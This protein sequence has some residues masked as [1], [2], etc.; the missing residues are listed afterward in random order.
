[1]RFRLRRTRPP[2]QPPVLTP[3]FH[4]L[5]DLP[6]AH[7]RIFMV[8]GHGQRDM[9]SS[10]PSR[11]P[12]Q[13]LRRRRGTAASSSRSWSPT[14]STDGRPRCCSTHRPR[15]TTRS[16]LV[17]HRDR[18]GRDMIRLLRVRVNY[19]PL[20]G[21]L[22]WNKHTPSN[23]SRRAPEANPGQKLFLGGSVLA[24]FGFATFAVLQRTVQ[25]G[26]SHLAHD[27]DAPVVT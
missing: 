11:R 6:V 15:S 5:Y 17:L 14:P 25:H 26:S 1:M 21:T 8:Y 2:R 22:T 10:F 3:R 4:V 18:G 19:R 13:R 20:P 23:G 12:P 16:G 9:T 27:A 7:L 24:D